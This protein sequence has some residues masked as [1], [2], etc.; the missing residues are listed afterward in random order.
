[1]DREPYDAAVAKLSAATDEQ[2]VVTALEEMKAVLTIAPALRASV[3]KQA[4]VKAAM[5]KRSASPYVGGVPVYASTCTC[6]HS[7]VDYDGQGCMDSNCCTPLWA[8][9]GCLCGACIPQACLPRPGDA[10]PL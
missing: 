2:G 10:S 5:T 9:V 6:T 1:M 8:T 4:V 7:C 3:T